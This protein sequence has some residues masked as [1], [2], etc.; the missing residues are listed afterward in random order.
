MSKYLERFVRAFPVILL[1]GSG[2][3]FAFPNMLSWF[4]GPWITFSLGG[5]MLGMGLTL[6]A[7]DFSYVFQ[8]P[9][10]V[11]LGTV[12]QFTI[13][14]GLG[15]LLG[16]VFSLPESFAI[17]LILVSACPGGTA[18]NVIAYL[19]RAD[20]ALSVTLTTVSTILGIVM[21]PLLVSILVGNRTE[22]DSFGLIQTTFLV[23]LIPVS[24]G[25]MIKKWS[26]N[27]SKEIVKISPA[28]SV[29]LITLIVGS[30]LSQGKHVI[31]AAAPSVF[32]SVFFL[33][34]GGF[35]LGGLFTWI[36]TK[37]QSITKTI[38][39]EVGMQNSGLGAVLARTHFLD[40]ST[41][42]PSAV[43]SLTHSLIGSVFASYFRVR[44]EK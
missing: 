26:P 12:L 4:K 34:I 8:K 17:G 30:I 43:S 23:I 7:K 5:I 42:I 29:V 35:G 24:L 28:I 15:Y 14:P 2:L 41:A 40:P 10:P 18:S 38:S 39:I 1:L 21:T 19:A 25:L 36:L 16:K 33:H 37:N 22:V 44:R 9:I 27:V 20:L 11:I 32:L 13:M 6:E 31:L 3:A